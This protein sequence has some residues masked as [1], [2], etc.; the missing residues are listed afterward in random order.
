MDVRE[1]LY[2]LAFA[3][4][5]AGVISACSQPSKLQEVSEP[6]TDKRCAGAAALKSRALVEWEDGSVTVEPIDDV[7]TFKTKFISPSVEKIKRVQFDQKMK[8]LPLDLQSSKP[9]QL[10]QPSNWGQ[11]MVEVDKLDSELAASSFSLSSFSLAEDRPNIVVG[12]V[13][14]FVDTKHVQLRDQILINEKETPDNDID[15]DGNGVIDDYRAG[16]FTSLPSSTDVRLAHGTHV[17]GII[18]ADPKKGPIRGIAPRVKIVPAQFINDDG[19][20]TLSDSIKALNY[21]VSR[22][23]KIVNASWGGP[24]PDTLGA[25][26]KNL[27]TQGV[28][29][30]VAAGNDGR[31]LE[32]FPTYPAAFALANQLTVAASTENDLMAA[33]SNSSFLSIHLAAPG[34]DIWSTVP[35][36]SYQVMSGTSMATPF[37]AGAAALLWGLRPEA[38]PAQIKNALM[39]SVDHSPTHGFRVISRGRLNVYEAYKKLTSL[40]PKE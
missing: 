36:N 10:D 8:L 5:L 30:I 3:V 13:D 6:L 15:D 28:L 25:V 20:G 17:A 40:M 24:C 16:Q 35:G 14:S 38:T 9:P 33:F 29:V 39:A 1:P 23:A 32:S 34:V 7:D 26:F 27:E 4:S 37:V 12:V 18:G 11:R 2:R 22:G 31:D 21:V 19:E